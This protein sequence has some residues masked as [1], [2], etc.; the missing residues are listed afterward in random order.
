[1]GTE[2]TANR[3]SMPAR[4]VWIV[5]ETADSNPRLAENLSLLGD[6]LHMELELVEWEA[7]IGGYNGDILTEDRKSDAAIVMEHCSD[8]TY[9]YQLGQVL[10]CAEDYNARILIWI[11]QHIREEH[12]AALDWL[13]R[14]T[15]DA[16]EVYGVEIRSAE[17]DDADANPEFAPVIAPASWS[18]R[19]GNVHIPKIQSVALREFFQ[20]LIDDLRDKGFTSRQ[21]ASASRYQPFTFDVTGMTCYASLE[22][23]GRCWVYIPG[24][25]PNLNEL[26]KKECR[27]KIEGELNICQGTNMAWR[28]SSSESLGVYRRAS[29]DNSEEELK[30]TRKWMS[31]YLRKFKEVFNP[32]MEKILAELENAES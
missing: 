13:N 26:R 2:E 31:Y 17:K 21:K 4:K 18:K 8:E 30:E 12:R 22:T 3:E 1:M 29:L 19:D 14:W 11:A 5:N 9:H 15:P 24:G 6:A 16:I 10:T 28:V 25:T 27:Q 23:D 32:R 20:P 7:L